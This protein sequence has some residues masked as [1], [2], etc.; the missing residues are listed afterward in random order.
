VETGGCAIEA[1]QEKEFMSTLGA[2]RVNYAQSAKRH[3]QD[4]LQLLESHRHGNAGQLFGFAAESGLKAILVACGVPTDADGGIP[5]KSPLRRHMPELG[6][7]LVTDGQLVPDGRFST[8]Y[9]AKL[10]RL[11]AFHDWSVD[12]RYWADEALPIESVSRWR[13]SAGEIMAMLDQANEDGVI[14]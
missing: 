14:R 4:A 1:R 13:D 2:V 12:Q 5:K 9:M 6:D 8:I 11:E 10:G 3:F 7:R